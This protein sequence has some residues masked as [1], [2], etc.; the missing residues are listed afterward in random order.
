MIHRGHP[1]PRPASPPPHPSCPPT[2]S[3]MPWAAT[4]HAWL[5]RIICLLPESSLL[6]PKSKGEVQGAES[7]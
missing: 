1:G 6:E 2:S 4:P 3:P 7:E 5:L